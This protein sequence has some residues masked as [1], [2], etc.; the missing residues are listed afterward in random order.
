M[1]SKPDMPRLFTALTIP[2]LSPLRRIANA[3]QQA[4]SRLRMEPINRWHITLNFLG[5]VEETQI[6]QL[7]G[8][9][10]E[11]TP[12]S[13]PLSVSLKGLEIGRAHV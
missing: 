1:N 4:D 2:P 11:V 5:T 3:L 6:P 8:L 9:L 10:R 13:E 12:Q 7:V